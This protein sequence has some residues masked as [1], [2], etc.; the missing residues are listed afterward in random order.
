MT[1]TSPSHSD[2]DLRALLMARECLYR[3]FS[4]ALQAPGSDVFK[5]LILSYDNQELALAAA[6]LLNEDYL[7]RIPSDRSE[8]L[9]LARFPSS[10]QESEGVEGVA[11]DSSYT[12]LEIGAVLSSLQDQVDLE[13]HY[14]SLFGLI[15]SAQCP[16]YE[17]EY[18][19]A[20]EPFHR[21]QQMADIAGFYR[22]FGLKP[23]SQQPERPDHVGLELEFMALLCMKQ[24]LALADSQPEAA[25]ICSQA[26]M[27]FFKDH[28]NWWL[29]SF[30]TALARNEDAVW[31]AQ[32]GRALGAFAL[33][34]RVRMGLPA[35]TVRAKPSFIEK[36]EEQPEC[37][38]WCPLAQTV[39]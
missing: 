10:E 34:E 14:L 32:L 2:E 28:L 9:A 26:Q 5:S 18:Y 21:V 23:G 4:A 1:M 8:P 30:A 6:K 27:D 11:Q 33:Q 7:S 22:A 37:P 25:K 35:P 29:H 39:R 19:P 13:Q 15:P 38:A 3:F 31:Y 16:P 12:L 20:S 24:R 36:P 17:T